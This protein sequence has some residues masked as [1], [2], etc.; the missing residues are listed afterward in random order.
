MNSALG[1]S[2]VAASTEESPGERDLVIIARLVHSEK[3]TIKETYLPSK[4]GLKREM[5][6]VRATA[7][8]LCV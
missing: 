2:A 8:A 4:S 7:A 6:V 3:D 1:K 5:T